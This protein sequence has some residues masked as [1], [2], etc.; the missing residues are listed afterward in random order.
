MGKTLTGIKFNPMNPGSDK[1][2][3]SS[4]FGMRTIKL[5]GVTKTSMHNGVDLTTGNKVYAIEEGTIT[6]IRGNIKGKDTKNSAGNYIKIKH[7]NGATSVYYHLAYGSL[8]VKT[9]DKVARGQ[10]LASEGA[11]G[12]VTGPHL[13]FGVYLNGKWVDPKPYLYGNKTLLSNTNNSTTATVPKPTKSITY[14]VKKGDNLTKIAK[15]YN[16]TVKRLVKDNNIKNKNL[17]FVGQ[18]IIIK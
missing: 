17:I 6:A 18:K 9:G 4:D 12:N 5:N 7:S 2:Y 13:H 15:K 14:I 16:T 11:T 8:K 1:I 10:F 3:M